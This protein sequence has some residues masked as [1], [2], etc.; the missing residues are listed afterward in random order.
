MIFP[1][2]TRTRILCAWVLWLAMLGL[3]TVFMH[4]LRRDIG[5]A[6]VVLIYLLLVLGASISGGRPFGFVI[7]GVGSLSIDYFFQ[8]PFDTL[9]IGKPLDGLVLIAF[10]AT[11]VVATQ[12]MALAHA[13]AERATAH[14]LEV[15]RLSAE[16]QHAGALRE[17][18][19]LKDVLL[20]SVSHDLRTPLTTI[21]ALAQDI[22]SGAEGAAENG[23]VIVTQAE[24]LGR[25]VGSLLDLSRLNS[26]SFPLSVEVNTAEDL[27]GAAVQQFTGVEGASRRLRTVIDYSQPALVGRF[28][29][30]QSLRILT[31]LIDNALR[32]SPPETP[33]NITVQSREG[34]LGFEVADRGV[35]IPPSER[36]R[37]FEPFY[38]PVGSRPDGGNAGLGLSISRRLA[39]A[40][41]GTV[42]YQ[43]GAHGGS[44]FALWLPAAEGDM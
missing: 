23:A 43:D 27:V 16:A 13:E 3:V 31:N 15:E 5:Q 35:G 2:H 40:Q 19:K 37:I 24:R 18:N 25:I 22:A 36:I 29:F 8:Q 28:D 9:T 30:V 34:M 10:L 11:A 33:V 41:G 26:E 38:R 6:H 4:V 32:Y 21:K 14:A 39:E 42:T 20:A 17:A 1:S 44:T 7:A 12:I